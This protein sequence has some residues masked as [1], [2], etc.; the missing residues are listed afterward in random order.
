ML[1]NIGTASERRK[2]VPLGNLKCKIQ[3]TLINLHLNKYNQVLQY[4]PFV[5]K[6]DKCIWSCSTLND[7]S[8]KVCIPNK[9]EDLNIHVFNMITNKKWIKILTW[10]YHANVNV[11]LMK[12]NVIQINS[13]ITINVDVSVKSIIFVKKIIFWIL[14][15]AVAEMENI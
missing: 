10:K 6:L 12:G 11:N 2:C 13:G 4:Y 3:S 1:T 9:T 8:N 14:L 5:V 7:L 15:H